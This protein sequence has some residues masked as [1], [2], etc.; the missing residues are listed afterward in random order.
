[1]ESITYKLGF[2]LSHPCFSN[3]LFS[4]VSKAP[5][6]WVGCSRGT[7]G[8]GWCEVAPPSGTES[9][10]WQQER[11]GDRSSHIKILNWIL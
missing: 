4:Q 9:A 10:V 7:S 3:L 6:S 8:F 1:M 11:G 5:F 2:L